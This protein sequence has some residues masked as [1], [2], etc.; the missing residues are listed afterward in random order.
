MVS[1]HQ[2]VIISEKYLH[3]LLQRNVPG[4]KSLIFLLNFILQG[5]NLISKLHLKFIFAER[6]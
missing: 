5:N 6:L 2:V 1:E 3:L 4:K